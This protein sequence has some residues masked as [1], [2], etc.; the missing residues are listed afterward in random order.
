[1]TALIG[2]SL[3]A[4]GVEGFLYRKLSWFKRVLLILGG[5][6]CMIPGWRS[7]AIGLVIGIPILLWEWKA[8]RSV[9]KYEIA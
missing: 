5:L 2:I 6:G 3:L 8:Y 1:M 7:D 9:K 4:I